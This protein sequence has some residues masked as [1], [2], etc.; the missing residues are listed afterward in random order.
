MYFLCEKGSFTLYVTPIGRRGVTGLA[1][2]R[3]G[4][5]EGKGGLHSAVT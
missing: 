5:T 2:K 1:M 3:Y 4:K